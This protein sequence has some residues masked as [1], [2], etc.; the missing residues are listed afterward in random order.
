MTDILHGLHDDIP[1]ARY[2]RGMGISK[3]GLDL[4]H[5]SP[6]L[7]RL[8]QQSPRPST[9]AQALGTA[10]HMMVLEPGRVRDGIVGDPYGASRSKEAIAWRAEQAAAGRLTLGMG[11]DTDP[12]S[13][14]PWTA[15]WAATDAVRAHPMARALLG[16]GRAEVSGYWT[17]PDFGVLCRLRADWLDEAHQVVVDLKTTRDAGM[18]SFSRSAVEYRYHV[19]AAFY[20]DGLVACGWVPQAFVFVCVETA[21]PYGVALYSV[22]PED[23]DL[24][25]AVYRRDLATYAECLRSGEWPGYP[26]E[27]RE[28][29]LPG[30]ARVVRV[31]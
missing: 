10:V 6:A 25:R 18:D 5:R 11:E 7:Y 26:E 27:I 22:K 23:L 30:W 21:P 17:D 16:T 24:G 31:R 1:A 2:H 9:P 4:I 29:E 8:T 28:L 14:T 15:A 3:S 19:Q 12:W 13:P 20:W